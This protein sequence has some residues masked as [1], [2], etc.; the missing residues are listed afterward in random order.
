MKR[1]VIVGLLVLVMAVGWRSYGSPETGTGTL[2]LPQPAPNKGERAPSF[3][4][5]TEDGKTFELKDKGIYVLTFWSTLNEGSSEARPA[6]T[7]LALRILELQRVLRGDLRQQHT[8]TP[9]KYS[10]HAT[11]G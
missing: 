10:L 3:T 9:G 11:S 5:Q 4:A 7:R 8:R 2:T 6:F 1:L